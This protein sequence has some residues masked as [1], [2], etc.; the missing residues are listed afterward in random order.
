ML[1][2]VLGA[3]G[4]ANGEGVFGVGANFAEPFL[5]GLQAFV[6]AI[7]GDAKLVRSG[8]KRM[9]DTEGLGGGAGV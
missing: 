2:Q 3:A 4:D 7:E 1:N 5:L 9:L 6:G 8:G